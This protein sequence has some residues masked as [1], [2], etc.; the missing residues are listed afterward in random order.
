MQPAT[1]RPNKVHVAGSGIL[2]G[3]GKPEMFW[4]V[5]WFVKI[6]PLKIARVSVFKTIL[7]NLHRYLAY[8]W[9]W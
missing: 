7:P 9:Q 3:I 4:F 5:P 2:S 1:A 6:V 8:R